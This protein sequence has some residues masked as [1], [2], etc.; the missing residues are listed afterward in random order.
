MVAKGLP[1]NKAR[2]GFFKKEKSGGMSYYDYRSGA[3]E[4]CRKPRFASIE[5]A[6]GC[7]TP[8]EKLKAVLSGDDKCAEF[9][10]RNLRD[11]MLYAAKLVPEIAPDVVN[12]DNA[13]KWGF[14]WEL[15][16]FEMLDALG[17]AEFIKRVEADG[18]E[19]PGSLRKV[20]R[21]YKHEGAAKFAW[22]LTTN[23]FRP[24]ATKPGELKLDLLRRAG[25]VVQS[26]QEASL[27]DLGDGVFGLEFHSK[28]NAIGSDTV[29]MISSAVARAEAEGI[30]LVIGNHGKAFSAGANLAMFAESIGNGQLARIDK[31]VRELQRA[32]MQ[33]KYAT[34]PVV[35]AP[36]GLTL[37][38]GC[39]VA[40]HADAVTA[41]AETNMGLVEIG[42]GL[43][44]AGGGT[45]E[46]AL[47]AMEL[48]YPYRADVQPF[49]TKLFMNIVKTKVSGCAAE[50]HDMGMLGSKDSITMDMDNLLSDAKQ[51][52][53]ALAV[54]YRPRREPD[55]L[56]A[57]GRS[58][59]A[60][61]KSQVWNMMAGGFATA[62]DFQIASLVADVITGGDVPPGTLIT[63]QHLLDLEREAFLSLC[64]NPKTL[65]RIEHMLKTGKALR[66]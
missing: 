30:G 63:E 58:I 24:L 31:L 26:N 1:G 43:L 8:A 25:K 29:A 20:G 2:Q 23:A 13:M 3:Y 16:P 18:L 6:A 28:L 65:Q 42:V 44:P 48:A 47:R 21:F 53:M 33:V 35:A 49:I 52:V 56:Q 36:F 14:G 10:W 27:F 32:L 7:T 66:N 41:H 11:T 62:Y 50:L 45:K 9:A 39:E 5:A 57:P 38:G 40:L 17:V 15:G 34:I 61:L 12:V 59:G 64:G 46:M 51:K 4:P 37:G 22:D 55:R 54:N 19:A 60:A